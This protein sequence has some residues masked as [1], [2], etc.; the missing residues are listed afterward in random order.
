MTL[1]LRGNA[2]SLNRAA[3]QNRRVLREKRDA[4]PVLFDA[5][6]VPEPERWSQPSKTTDLQNPRYS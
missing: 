3:E 6:R 5:E 1:R 4:D 2:I